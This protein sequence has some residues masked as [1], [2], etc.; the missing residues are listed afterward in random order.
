MQGFGYVDFR[1][2]LEKKSTLLDNLELE[3]PLEP[4]LLRVPSATWRLLR[5]VP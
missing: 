1:V 3:L 2:I 4:K 5:R